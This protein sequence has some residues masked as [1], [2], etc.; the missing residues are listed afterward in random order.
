MCNSKHAVLPVYNGILS[1][2]TA[3]WEADLHWLLESLEITGL[4][5]ILINMF[6]NR[7]VV[8]LTRL[9]VMHLYFQFNTI[10]ETFNYKTNI[11]NVQVK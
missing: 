1:L 3:T 11:K 9:N 4:K 6:S 8:I 7:R 5:L 10:I 2:Q